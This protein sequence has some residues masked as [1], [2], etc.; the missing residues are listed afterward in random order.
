MTE[1]FTPGCRIKSFPQLTKTVVWVKMNAC[2]IVLRLQSSTHNRF[3]IHQFPSPQPV[4]ICVDNC[5]AREDHLNGKE[6]SLDRGA[7]FFHIG[8]VGCGHAYL[9]NPHQKGETYL[10]V[11]TSAFEKIKAI[12]ALSAVAV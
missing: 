6:I 11:P 8:D 7:E 4:A 10:L 5:T 3:M 9:K 2:R 1:T 12:S